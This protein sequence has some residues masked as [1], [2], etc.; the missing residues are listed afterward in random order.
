MNYTYDMFKEF[1]I[2][3]LN[4]GYNPVR[5]A[6]NAFGIYLKY[7][8]ISSDV[9]EK[10]RDLMVMDEGPEFELAEE[11]IK[12]WIVTVSEKEND[13]LVQKLCEKPKTTI[14]ESNSKENLDKK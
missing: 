13:V 7:G 3:E 6:N 10:L 14:Q 11:T 4:N 2:C 5:M 1:L 9:Y 12:E 8:E